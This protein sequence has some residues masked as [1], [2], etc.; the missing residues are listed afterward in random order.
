MFIRKT[1]LAAL[2][3]LVFTSVLSAQERQVVVTESKMKMEGTSN[4]RDWD[5]DIKNMTVN[6]Q[7]SEGVALNNLT[8]EDFRSLTVEIPVQQIESSTRGLASNI[9]KYLKYDTH[10]TIRFQMTSVAGVERVGTPQAD[11]KVRV[12]GNLSVAG[13]TN[14]ITLDVFTKSNP[15]G[16][17]R[18]FATHNLLM[19]DYGIDPPTAVMGTVRAVNELSVI[20]EITFRN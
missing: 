7:V 3:L 6:F 1:L 9:Q 14:A 2:T 18:F 16:T 4:I 10:P 15:N 12:N 19:T 11:Q 5:G 13:K 17:T 20:F 8:A